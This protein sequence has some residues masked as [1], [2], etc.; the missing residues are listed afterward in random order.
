MKATVHSGVSV[1]QR[2][3]KKKLLTYRSTPHASVAPC[4]LFLKHQLQTRFGLLRPDQV[5]YVESKQA[6]L[7]VNH[8]TRSRQCEFAVEQSVM[9]HNLRSVDPYV[10]ATVI[11]KLGPVTYPV[12]TRDG[13]IWN[14]HIEQL[15]NLMATS[16]YQQQ[17]PYLDIP[18]SEVLP[19]ISMAASESTEGQARPDAVEPVSE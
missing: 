18:T 5:R 8:D 16:H 1:N 11:S 12:R 9:A 10:H 4:M 2:I 17:W 14:H 7:K 19:D 15:K 6:Q 13:Q 3:N